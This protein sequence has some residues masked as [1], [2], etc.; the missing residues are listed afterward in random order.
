M[1]DRYMEQLRDPSLPKLVIREYVRMPSA[2]IEEYID[3]IHDFIHNPDPINPK[4]M[5]IGYFSTYYKVL[6]GLTENP[7]NPY[8]K[9]VIEL[10]QRKMPNTT[11]IILDLLKN[12]PALNASTSELKRFLN[13]TR[14]THET[15]GIG[16]G[17]VTINYML[18]NVLDR[19]VYDKPL[20]STQ[21]TKD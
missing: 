14:D 5:S 11:P 13:E 19:L 10:M 9:Q 6:K 17:P 21:Y 4:Y 15:T 3:Q 20:L 12:G 7:N 1:N 2:T 18:R 16:S 8:S